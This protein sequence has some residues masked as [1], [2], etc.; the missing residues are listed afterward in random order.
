MRRRVRGLAALILGL[1]CAAALAAGCTS[2]GDGL[3]PEQKVAQAFLDALGRGD[4]AAA[5]AQ[6][7]DAAAAQP[8]IAAF[9]G[10]LQQGEDTAKIDAK[11][12]ITGLAGRTASAATADASFSWTIPGATQPWV[13]SN[14][15]PMAKVPTS[16]GS[17]DTAWK[18]TWAPSSLHPQLGTGA[19]ITVVRTQPPRADLLDS[20]GQP[21]FTETGVVTVGVVPNQVSDPAGEAAIL[22]QQLSISA[23]DIVADIA[24]ALPD[25]GDQFVEVVTVRRTIYEQAR[26]AIY[27]LPGVQFRTGTMLLAPSAAFARQLLGTV[28]PATADVID[29]S[30]G[31][32]GPGDQT[33]LGG[34]Q[35]ALDAELGGVAGLEIQLVNPDGSAGASLGS[36]A[37]PKPGQ[38]VQLTIDTATQNAADGALA[39]LSQQASLVVMQP[40][41]GKVLAVA[42]SA[43]AGDDIALVGQYPPGSTFKIITA[44]A[45]LAGTPGLTPDTPQDC[46]ATI[47]VDGRQFEN[48]NQFALGQVD[49]R[50]AFA[51]SCNTTFIAL[52][53]S[54]PASA[55]PDQ[56]T[57][58]GLGAD[59]ALP[60]DSF[61]GSVPAPGSATVQAADSIGQGT[62]LMSPLAM[63][64]V[65]AA[66]QSGRPVAP[67]LTASGTQ[68]P[69]ADLPAAT[70]A[71]L[72]DMMRAV[73]T[74]GTATNLA[75]VPGEVAGKTGTAEYG[76]ETPPRAHSWF[77]G[78]RG[79]LAFAVFV[80]DGQSAGVVAS[81]V[82]RTFLT[83]LPA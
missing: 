57:A 34:L 35:Q 69:G 12:A 68:Q 73:V 45:A 60:V 16:P 5:A 72:H 29:A 82:A 79:D 56:A 58:F 55:L 25:R 66:A 20:A 31:R 74:S 21:I 39:A 13:Y 1:A 32:L 75:A 14:T 44:S 48:Q 24:A 3:P 78:Y 54:L 8:V 37:S 71:A 61:S 9:Y 40:S 4:A 6:T 80:A 23:D 51:R 7:T 17:G 83:A 18:V 67:S 36:V 77:V 15:L 27:D 30:H 10:A 38:N 41:T 19:T 64:A 70:V 43:A 52:G 42:N 53:T 49:L 81:E 59:W 28:G 11:L 47:T 62:V 76:E 33:G 46:P 65:A 2:G 63:A 26:D 50:T 22:A